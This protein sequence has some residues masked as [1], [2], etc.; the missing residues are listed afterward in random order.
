MED[1][2][3]TVMSDLDIESTAT[4]LKNMDCPLDSNIRERIKNKVYTKV[5]LVK[6]TN[7][8]YFRVPSIVAA[9]L[10]V[11]LFG[12]GAAY[13]SGIAQFFG[14][15]FN[16][17]APLSQ[18][19]SYLLEQTGQMVQKKATG[20]GYSV[21]ISA[22]VGDG[23]RMYAYI[24]V[25]AD[26]G[27]A[28]NKAYRFKNCFLYLAE[29]S[30][31]KNTKGQYIIPEALADENPNDNEVNFIIRFDP[32]IE[33][34]GERVNLIG[35]E[36]A[37]D[38]QDL[39]ECSD[40]GS[41][42][43]DVAYHDWEIPLTIRDKQTTLAVSFQDTTVPLEGC[44]YAIDEIR[45]SPLSLNIDGTLEVTGNVENWASVP[46]SIRQ[47]DGTLIESFY[48]DTVSSST[49]DMPKGLIAIQKNIIFFRPIDPSSVQSVRIN[50]VEIELNQN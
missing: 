45:L 9:S 2:I 29:D 4:L 22:V 19:E 34:F 48:E 3:I 32:F 36:V 18:N 11:L 33:R 1:K 13:Y 41:I 46:I 16:N 26:D 24:R 38:F 7:K 8:R 14:S 40:N 28:M 25:S 23:D 47:K 10:V 37:I 39:M 6:P 35:A 44:D 17:G 15:Y 27:T 21:E 31:H 20:E 12:M 50:G 5:G 49:Q 30:E 42:I 43:T